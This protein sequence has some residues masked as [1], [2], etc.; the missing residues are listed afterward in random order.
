MFSYEE[1]IFKASR[2][3][4]PCLKSTHVGH[5][6]S[7]GCVDDSVGSL[8][9]KGRVDVAGEVVTGLSEGEEYESEPDEGEMKGNSSG[10]E[11]YLLGIAIGSEVGSSLGADTLRV[12][13]AGLVPVGNSIGNDSSES[14]AVAV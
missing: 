7:A 12:L 4:S 6:D 9:N 2:L 11:S 1:R 14:G 13:S 3:S 10:M 8:E 5:T